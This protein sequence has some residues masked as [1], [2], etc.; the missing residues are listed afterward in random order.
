MKIV[1]RNREQG[2]GSITWFWDLGLEATVYG[3]SGTPLALVDDS[4]R[5]ACPFYDRTE[6]FGYV[7]C[8]V[9]SRPSLVTSSGR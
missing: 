9:S 1:G 6:A 3:A 8:R 5:P 4:S 7:H 2:A